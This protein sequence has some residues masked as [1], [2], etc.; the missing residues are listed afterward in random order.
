MVDSRSAMACASG[1][2]SP[3]PV[4]GYSGQGRVVEA[5]LDRGEDGVRRLLA[6]RGTVIDRYRC[7]WPPSRKGMFP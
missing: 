2:G 3:S 6:Q 1:A 7:S 4:N 5:F